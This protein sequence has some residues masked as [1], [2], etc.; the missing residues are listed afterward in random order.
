M[1]SIRPSAKLGGRAANWPGAAGPP[2]LRV[3][4]LGSGSSGNALLIESGNSALL[5]DCGVPTRALIA[6]LTDLT[7]GADSL[8]AILI[9]HEHTDHVR[10]L[11]YVCGIDAPLLATEGT[12]RSLRLG[13]SWS[14][15][16]TIRSETTV[17]PFQ[18]SAIR[19]SHDAAEPCGF[20]VVAARR[21]VT[22]LTDLG[23]A[24]P[25]LDSILATSDLIV[26]EANHD[27]A[28]LRDGPYPRHLKQRITSAAGHL[29]NAQCAALL[30]RSLAGSGSSPTIWLAHLSRT[31][32][33]PALAVATVRT[34]L[35][36][37]G[38][39]ATITAL[40]RAG[41]HQTWQCATEP[42]RQLSLP[43]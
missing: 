5:V 29:S 35:L 31:N 32:N 14:T 38:I 40:S 17:G 27:E 8:S 20:T 18:V 43:W 9:S 36:E 26:V 3:R 30:A 16:E 13:R 42:V 22:V 28:M 21:R 24:E 2:D 10:S 34:Q 19:V 15:Q 41:V 11:P 23:T 25:H 33:L 12:L 6:G 37:A 1:P 39:H 4:S 7:N